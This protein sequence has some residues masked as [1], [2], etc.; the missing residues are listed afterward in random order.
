MKNLLIYVNPR[1][2]WDEENK[3]LIKLQIDNSFELG[4]KKEDILLFTNFP[5]EYEG[6]VS[7][8][9]PDELFCDYFHQMSKI[10][11]ILWMFENDLIGD[12]T[13]WFHDMEALQNYPIKFELTSDLAFTDYG[14]CPKFNTGSLFFRKESRDV[15]ELIKR[16]SDLRRGGEERALTYLTRR[17]AE[18]INDRYEV[19]NIT[20][21]FP[22]S[23][24]ADRNFK[25]LYEKADKPIMVVHFHPDNYRGK[26]FRTMIGDND[27]HVS[28]MTNRL[29]KLFRKY[30]WE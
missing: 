15:L 13:Y 9:V 12:D 18:N 2:D 4:W 3:K 16:E 8:V 11:T 7:T 5:Y 19:I 22:G 23:V 21:N 20:Y 14:Y 27:L 26:F 30:G 29:T 25:M 28:V 17:N 10:N 1:K 24:N 6:I